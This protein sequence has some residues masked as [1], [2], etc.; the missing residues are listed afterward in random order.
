MK[1][2]PAGTPALLHCP[3]S[4]C[5]ANIGRPCDRT[6]DRCLRLE[7]GQYLYRTSEPVLQVL[8]A[9]CRGA[10]KTCELSVGGQQ[11]IAGIHYA[12][13]VVG[14][15]TIGL[16]R[17]YQSA[18]ALTDT[19]VYVCPYTEL[20]DGTPLAALL[21]QQIA[22]AQRERLLLTAPAEQRIAAFVL[23][24]PPIHPCANRQNP[25]RTMPMTRAEAGAYLGMA[26]T[27][28]SRMLN[29]FQRLH[30][31]TIHRTELTICNADALTYI[32]GPAMSSPSNSAH[33]SDGMGE[34]DIPA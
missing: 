12:G 16:R 21:S 28:I 23:G 2:T 3:S 14:L 15:G 20:V 34:S 8:Y 17:H 6:G 18:I 26:D 11:R 30:Y 22:R 4:S 27:T 7:R 32:A 31:L 10:V 25:V 1:S 13:D 19:V 9:I 24:L 33:A 29:R 5:C